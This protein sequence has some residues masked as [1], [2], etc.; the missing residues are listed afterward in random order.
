MILTAEAIKES[1]KR[2]NIIIDPYN[3]DNLN[4]NS[5]DVR[6]D[7]T[8][9]VYQMTSLTGNLISSIDLFYKTGHIP[10]GYPIDSKK[11]NFTQVITMEEDGYLLL[12]GV[13]Y[14]GSTVEYTETHGLVPMIE[15]KSSIGRLGIDVHKTAGFGDLSFCGQWTLEITVVQPVIIYPYMKIAQLIYN[16]VSGNIT[17]TYNG[18][19]QRQI[20][21]IPSKSYQD[22]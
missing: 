7:N 22:F 17:K 15:G 4:P 2:R 12:P 16:E 21:I 19:Y 10:F 13:L 5:Y 8:L 20:G 3:E 6:L 1:I 9:Q 14:L 11:Q 18:K